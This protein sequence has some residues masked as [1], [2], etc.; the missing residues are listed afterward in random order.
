M[1]IFRRGIDRYLKILNAHPLKMQ[2]AS[3][4][5]FLKEIFDENS[6]LY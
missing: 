2:M 1:T 4:R 5:D 6:D 3:G